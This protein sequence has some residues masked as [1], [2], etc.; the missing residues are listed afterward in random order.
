MNREKITLELDVNIA[1]KLNVYAG[2][3]EKIRADFINDLLDDALKNYYIVHTGGMI[4]T[5]PNPQFYHI[6]KYKALE[7]LE[8]IKHV[9]DECAT[10]NIPTGLYALI[11]FLKTRVIDDDESR[12]NFFKQNLYSIEQ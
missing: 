5:V 12:R 1:K 6:D 3:D 7:K 10:A 8:M 11:N 4:L 9:A 2:L